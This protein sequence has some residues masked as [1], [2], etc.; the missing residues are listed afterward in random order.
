MHVPHSTAGTVRQLLQPAGRL[1][2][3]LL[4]AVA[5]HGPAH[6]YQIEERYDTAFQRAGGG[7]GHGVYGAPWQ[8]PIATPGQRS[9]YQIIT[10]GTTTSPFA[11]GR[12]I[13]GDGVAFEST[14]QGPA[15][16]Y[17]NIEQPFQAHAWAVASNRTGQL[18]AHAHGTQF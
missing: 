2:A 14:V 10:P 11:P 8:P 18:V 13:G 9:D 3:L 16:F 4:A 6:A 7:V 17:P 5:H 15:V 12:Y 1:A